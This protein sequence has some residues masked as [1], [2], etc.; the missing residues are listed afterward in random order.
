MA[1][2]HALVAVSTAQLAAAVAGQLVALRRRRNYDVGFMRGSPEHVG[3]DSFW[4]GTA[5]SAPSYM[6]AAQAWAI[7]RLR[8]GPDD[9][10][11][12]L[13][14]MLGVVM[15]PGY[16]MERYGRAHLRPGGLDPIETPILLAGVGLAAAMGVLGHRESSG[17]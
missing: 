2:R 4:A 5:Y 12:R 17:G 7:A 1:P 9:G 11:R 10:A 14:G 6:L 8:R 13:L 15:V 16:L 3:R